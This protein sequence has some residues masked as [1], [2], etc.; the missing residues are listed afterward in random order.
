MNPKRFEIFGIIK[1][2]LNALGILAYENSKN[3]LIK[4]SFCSLFM[5]GY[6]AAIFWFFL[7]EAK[8]FQE[9]TESFLF[10]FSTMMLMGAL[11]ILFCQRVTFTGLLIDLE[12]L[13]T[14]SKLIKVDWFC[15]K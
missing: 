3:N 9:I 14:E 6:S 5:S 8:T 7:F 10:V 4:F 1:S 12:N 13:I 15:I 11:V 2:H